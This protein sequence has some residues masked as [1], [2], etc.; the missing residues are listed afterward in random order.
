M[1][2]DAVKDEHDSSDEYHGDVSVTE[3][4]VDEPV[5][6]WDEEEQCCNPDDEHFDY[7]IPEC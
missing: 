1:A 7:P 4:F 2:V 5:G 6:E 3:V